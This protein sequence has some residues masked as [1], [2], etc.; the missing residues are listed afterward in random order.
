M[1][2]KRSRQLAFA[3]MAL[4]VLLLA[5]RG[6]GASGRPQESV[7]IGAI[8]DLSQQPGLVEG[9]ILRATLD[10]AVR[11]I[12]A[13]GGINGR[14]LQVVF[15]DPRND[16]AEALAQVRRVV[17]RGQVDVLY[18]G[19]LNSECAAVQELAGRVHVAYVMGNACTGE[20]LTSG[21]CNEYSFRLT[22]AGRQV[23][24]PLAAYITDNLGKRWAVIYP[25]YLPGRTQVVDWQDSLARAGGSVA[26]EIAV[27][28]DAADVSHYLLTI[29]A[30]GAIS[31]IILAGS[32]AD[33]RRLLDTISRFGLAE[34]YPVV[35]SGDWANYHD[36]VTNA[37]RGHL[38][39]VEIQ[40]VGPFPG[41]QTL[42]S[43]G[44]S[45]DEMA[46]KALQTAMV[47]S[48]FADRTD[49]RQLIAALENIAVA[50]GANDSEPDVMD[51]ADH[52][53]RMEENILKIQGQSVEVLQHVSPSQL[54]RIGNCHV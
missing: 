22:P 32:T 2:P 15:L 14:S 37:A 45:N 5:S 51:K 1:S 47:A 29:P 53:G 8:A 46:I 4:G 31:G 17:S 7:R 35:G 43:A 10:S 40:P 26:A 19:T 34:R 30:D 41:D 27:P 18:G 28:M 13:A 25:D 42:A 9:K 24:D 39:L 49:T 23:T 48:S 44:A 20:E 12:N 16:P 11:Q 52:Q 33:Q 21:T 38:S 36:A 3:L 54:P 50:G 6:S